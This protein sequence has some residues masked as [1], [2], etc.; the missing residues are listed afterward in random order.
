MDKHPIKKNCYWDWLPLELQAEVLYW[1]RRQQLGLLHREL[2]YT[3]PLATA[4]CE[5]FS[6]GWLYWT[7]DEWKRGW[8]MNLVAWGLAV[9]GYQLWCGADTYRCQQ[10]QVGAQSYYS[11]FRNAAYQLG[12]V[13][14]SRRP[15]VFRDLVFFTCHD[16]N[17]CNCRGEPVPRNK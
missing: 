11:C 7:G 4:D 15:L 13:P 1:R 9:L 6:A 10:Q 3:V 5:Q 16:F 12:A 14:L 17:P 2:C 8:S